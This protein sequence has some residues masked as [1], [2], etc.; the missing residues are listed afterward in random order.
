MCD[1]PIT[2]CRSE[3]YWVGSE[4]GYANEMMMNKAHLMMVLML[5]R[6]AVFMHS[7]VMEAG[8]STNGMPTV[9]T[10]TDVF[11]TFETFLVT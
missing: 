8:T 7:M 3:Q 6:M 4:C 5:M 1:D 9:A 10:G 2:S 11:E